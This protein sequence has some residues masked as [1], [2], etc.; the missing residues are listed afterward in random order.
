M[1]DDGQAGMARQF[2]LGKVET[3]LARQIQAGH[4]VV[5]PDLANGHQA[6]VVAVLMQGR[7]QGLQVFIGGLAHPQRVQ[8]QGVG[9]AMRMG[10]ITHGVEMRGRH[11]GQHQASHARGPGALHHGST[12]GIEFGRV[13]VTVCVGPHGWMMAQLHRAAA[14]AGG[15]T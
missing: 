13:Q 6:W 4:E 12:V 14:A 9:A 10:Q 3:R 5:Q 11:R 15:A 8:P 7:G 2:Q 1:Q